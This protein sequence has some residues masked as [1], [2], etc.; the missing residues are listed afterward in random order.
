MIIT[1]LICLRAW[2]TGSGA[3]L[4]TCAIKYAVRHGYRQVKLSDTSDFLELYQIS[5]SLMP[6]MAIMGL[7]GG[8]HPDVVC[9]NELGCIIGAEQERQPIGR[10]GDFP[11]PH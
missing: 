9:K 10:P 2:P 4:L 5:M 1:L 7:S 6:P 8:K 3:R 11:I